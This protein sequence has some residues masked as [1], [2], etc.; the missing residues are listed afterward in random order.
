MRKRRT[1][2]R[3]SSVLRITS[4]DKDLPRSGSAN[5]CSHGEQGTA[6][7]IRMYRQGVGENHSSRT[8]SWF[9]R[10]FSFLVAG[11]IVMAAN[12]L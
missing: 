8:P 9:G 5:H 4:I 11:K 1:A 7:S 12:T 6:V 3:P 10:T 2:Y